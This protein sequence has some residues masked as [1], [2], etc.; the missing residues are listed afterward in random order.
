MRSPTSAPA[1]EAAPLAP[2]PASRSRSR[3][4]RQARL[5]ALLAVIAAVMLIPFALMLKAA[6]TSPAGAVPGSFSSGHLT[7]A[8]FRAA[9]DA[10]DWPR[11]YLNSCFVVLAI[12]VLQVALSLPA[13]YVL[14]R[15]AFRGQKLAFWFVIACLNIPAQVTALPMF[16]ALSRVGWLDS[17]QAL[18]L[19][20]IGSGFGI[21]ILRQYLVSI[22]QSVFDAARIDRVGP[23]AMVWR[24]V[25]PNARPAI[26]AFAT[27]SIVL[28]WNDLFW[29]SVV[30]LTD[31][32]A[33]VTYAIA[34]F[35]G[36]DSTAPYTQQMAA[37]VLAIIP[38]I[39]IYLVAQKHLVKGLN[40]TSGE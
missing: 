26:V 23:M 38:L 31:R 20:W 8:N 36:A 13:A 19:P 11:L 7:L 40:L 15:R 37:A 39:V 22:P 2:R 6:F 34:Q 28:H 25:L 32:S 10:L 33:T 16:Y 17:D 1:T 24:V 18:I 14:A 4:L 35:A 21:F 9:W 3:L 30:L 27:F 12:A 5:H 29:P